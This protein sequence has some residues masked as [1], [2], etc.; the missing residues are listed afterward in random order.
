MEATCSSETLVDFQRTAYIPEDKTLQS[1]HRLLITYI[2]FR[3]KER[4][5]T[6]LDPMQS[7]GKSTCLR[8]G[9]LL[10]LF[11]H[12]SSSSTRIWEAPSQIKSPSPLHVI[13]STD[14]SKVGS[15][16]AIGLHLNSD[17]LRARQPAGVRILFY[18]SAAYR[19]GLWG[20]INLL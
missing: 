19:D 2:K 13:R 5:V 6:L 7:V 10:K 4:I 18:S 14:H 3:V 15:Q 12:P 11:L 8:G 1:R 17:K 16:Y 20:L 9:R